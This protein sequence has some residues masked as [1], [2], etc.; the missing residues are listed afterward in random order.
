MKPFVLTKQARADLIAIAQFT[1]KRWGKEQRNLY[2]KQFD[3]TFHLLAEMPEIGKSCD[4]IRKGYHKFPQGS[5]LIFFKQS[6]KNRIE[7]IRILH[8][9]MD[10]EIHL[11]INGNDLTRGCPYSH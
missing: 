11:A 4:E 8:K 5:H 10:V 3:D 2:I 6:S 9:S 7:I 1:M